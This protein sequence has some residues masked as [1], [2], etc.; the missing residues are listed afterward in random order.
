VADTVICMEAFR[1]RDVTAEAL[2]I[3][4]RFGASPALGEAGGAPY[5]PVRLPVSILPGSPSGAPPHSAPASERSAVALLLQAAT[6]SEMRI[7]ST[8]VHKVSAACQLFLRPPLL[9]THRTGCMHRFGTAYALSRGESP[10]MSAP[11]RAER[12]KVHV[13]QAG[14]IGLGDQE[15]DLGALAQLVEVSQTRAVAEA[16]LLL[17]Q[18]RPAALHASIH[19]E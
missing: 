15:L 5:P 16:L 18:A 9:L 3:D 13:R 14:A 6:E 7:S 12:I 11:P 10:R 19:I 17:R 4:A 8:Q 2:A 1:A